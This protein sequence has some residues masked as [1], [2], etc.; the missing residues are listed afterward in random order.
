MPDVADQPAK[1]PRTWRP[2]AYWAGG[3]FAALLLALAMTFLV[4]PYVL[5][6]RMVTGIAGRG[7][8]GALPVFSSG[9]G[10]GVSVPMDPVRHQDTAVPLDALLD[11]L[12]EYNACQ[13]R[14]S[15]GDAAVQKTRVD[16][17]RLGG[18]ERAAPRLALYVRLPARLAPHRDV[19]AFLLGRCGPA[20]V[21]VLTE[22]LAKGDP[23]LR[24][25][26]IESLGQIGEAAGPAVPALAGLLEDPDDRVRNRA[27]TVLTR[28][29]R[30]AATVLAA[31]LEH[32]EWRRTA[33]RPLFEIGAEAR[34]AVPQLRACLNTEDEYVRFLALLT[35]SR[36]GP[37]AAP[38]LPEVRRLMRETGYCHRA[39]AMETLAHVGPDPRVDRPF[40]VELIAKDHYCRD[41]AVE[42]LLSMGPDVTDA[43]PALLADINASRA[44]GLAPSMAERAL[45]S[46][47]A[48]A[49]PAL[50]A[51]IRKRSEAYPASHNAIAASEL[52]RCM[53][54]EARSAVPELLEMLASGD[55]TWTCESIQT[56]GAIGPDARA[57]L[58]RLTAI[59]EDPE[60]V[61]PTRCLAAVA[62]GRIGG[63][64]RTVRSL[65]AILNNER[66]VYFLRAAAAEGLGWMGPDA[67][68]ASEALGNLCLGRMHDHELLDQEGRCLATY[69]PGLDQDS[70]WSPGETVPMAAA[71]ALARVRPEVSAQV[72]RY[73]VH[74]MDHSGH[75]YDYTSLRLLTL[76]GPRAAPA[77]PAMVAQLKT[78]RREE[79]LSA[80]AAVGPAAAEAVPELI[81]LLDDGQCETT[82]AAVLGRIGPG[83]GE[84]VGKLRE[85]R[86]R[87]YM[88]AERAARLA[89]Q[90]IAPDE[91]PRR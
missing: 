5:V 61:A 75:R 17:D 84:A 16:L 11:A 34:V 66:E 60:E 63:G 44:A 90:R 13:A 14:R 6:R 80:L 70:F 20:A 2:M 10:F 86:T 42:M 23:D 9:G 8:G 67:A 59:L 85:L 62:V 35:L 30:P 76:L 46:V 36:I 65:L 47:G 41:D 37:E 22:L 88:P 51:L 77:V 4:V 79:A 38:A 71:G 43:I 73:L 45:V 55:R 25:S 1:P 91:P 18:P 32:E 15:A 28:I 56:L 74:M 26:A 19:A 29:G 24:D 81:K 54:P 87:G 64:E 57:T 48:P 21:P 12:A 58:P 53:G 49:V 72:C 82:T 33:L 78:D 83:A 31:A 89:L 52:L 7:G 39:R 69:A 27:L 50:M 3:A 68:A 40:I